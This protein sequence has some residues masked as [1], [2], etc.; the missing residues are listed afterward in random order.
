[1]RVLV[2]GAQ[3]QLARSLVERAAVRDGIEIVALGRPQLDLESPGS[4]ELAIA[5]AAPDIVVNAA[6]Y[7]AVDAAEDEPGRAFRINGEAAGEVAAAAARI[8]APVI[9]ISTDYVFDGTSEQP[10]NEE[11]VTNPLN[12]YGRSKLEGEE[13]AR[14]ANKNHAIVRTSWIYSPFGRNFIRTIM[15]AADTLQKLDVVNDQCG[16]PSS[17][18]DLADGLLRMVEAGGANSGEIYH[19][20]GTGCASWYDF[21]RQVMAERRTHGLYPIHVHAISGKTW[22]AKAKRPRHS[23]LDSSKFSREFGFVMPE[24][25]RS[26]AEVVGRLAESR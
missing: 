10:Y 14:T 23:V 25:Q 6:A 21:A 13:R 8:G 16:S 1:M 4:A 15:D 5:T 26:L 3:G 24:W 9:Q 7:T 20:G 22:A 19:L 18:L 11:S 12:V 17:A 2:T